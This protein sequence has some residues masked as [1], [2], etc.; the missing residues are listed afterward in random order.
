MVTPQIT[1][2]KNALVKRIRAL[3][4][5]DRRESDDRLVVEG[6][7]MIEEVLASGAPVEL[8][9]YD[10]KA[11]TGPRAAVLLERARG[12]G[13]RLVTAT[14]HVVAA[15]SQ[16]DTP[17]GLVAIVHHPR[18]ALTAVLAAPDLV[19]VVADRIQDP[20]NLGTIIRI[21]DAA[22]A[23]AVLTTQGTV[24]PYNP[25]VVRATMGSLFHLP[26]ASA[27]TPELIAVLRA[28]SVR[29]L[30][31]D[32]TGSTDYTQADYRSPVAIVFG[33]EAGGP[34]LAWRDATNATVRIPVYG[35]ADSLNV[36]VAAALLLY[37]IR[38]APRGSGR[39]H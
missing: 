19:V 16:V 2:T 36:A 17:Q 11:A 13:V 9:L 32:P 38:R 37:E 15:C 39:E 10:P 28:R 5:R 35:R 1:S 26:V 20:G 24:D 8:L 25:K 27:A 3:A 12:L 31:A 23:T 21:A 6:V 18:P 33:S 29:I 7:R 4:D 14:P 34:D 22:G 30:L